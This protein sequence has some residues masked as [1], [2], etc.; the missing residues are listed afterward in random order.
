MT[1]NTPHG[2]CRSRLDPLPGEALDSWLEA[3]APRLPVPLNDLMWAIGL[4]GGAHR[5]SSRPGC[6]D[7]TI[8][9]PPA[10][11]AENLQAAWA[12]C[13]PEAGTVE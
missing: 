1:R 4:P 9:L 5:R 8:A 2:P 6:T 7:R 13:L 3:I 12:A 10:E 11:A